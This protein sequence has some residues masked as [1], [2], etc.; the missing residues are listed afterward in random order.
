MLG[1]LLTL[2]HTDH[3]TVYD[4]TYLKVVHIIQCDML[5]EVEDLQRT[6]NCAQSENPNA[7][8]SILCIKCP[9]GVHQND[10]DL[11][12]CLYYISLDID[13]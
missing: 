4:S 9:L 10:C 5:V 13:I 12:I 2:R 1:E 3:S 11:Y 8:V 7:Y 6:S